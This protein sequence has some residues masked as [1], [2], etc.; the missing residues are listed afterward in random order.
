MEEEEIR[1]ESLDGVTK[2]VHL[3]CL[4]EGKGALKKGL[5]LYALNKTRH[6]GKDDRTKHKATN[7]SEE[8]DLGARLSILPA[9]S[10]GQVSIAICRFC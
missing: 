10:S 2:G 5:A 6:K 1:F 8:S 3:R 7:H 4:D 9:C